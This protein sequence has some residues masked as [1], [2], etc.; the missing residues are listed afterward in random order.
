MS[1]QEIKP[2]HKDP[3]ETVPTHN[4]ES[5]IQCEDFKIEFYVIW[6]SG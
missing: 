5:P 3:A 1:L 2:G 4:S 6:R